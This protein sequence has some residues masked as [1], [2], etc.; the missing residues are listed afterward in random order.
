MWPNEKTAFLIIHGIGEQNPFET[1]DLFATTFLKVLNGKN[2]GSEIKIK[3]LLKPRTVN[4][5]IKWVENYISLVKEDRPGCPIDFYEYYWAHKMEGK[6]TFPEIVDWLIKISDGAKTFYDENESI[7]KEYERNKDDAFK[8]GRFKS[9]W[10]LKHLGWFLRLLTFLRIPKIPYFETVFEFIRPIVNMFIGKAKKLFVDYLGDAAIYTTT[11]VKSKHYA[12]R[13]SILDDSVD[14]VKALIEDK[15]Y[16]KIIIAGHSLGSVVAFDTLNRINHGMNVNTIDQN[17]ATKF[18]GFITF[19]SPLDKIAFFFREHVPIDQYLRRQIL[20]HFHSF[21]AKDLNLSSNF[22]ANEFK[23]KFMI[24]GLCDAI[25]RDGYNIS[26]NTPNN[27]IDWLNKL[28]K[29]VNFYDELNKKKQEIGFSEDIKELV[30]KT[31]NYRN[32]KKFSDLKNEEQNTIKRL[33]R[34]LLEETYPDNTPKRPRVINPFEAL[35]DE[36]TWINFYDDDNDPISGHLDYYKGVENI[37]CDGM[38]TQYGI[39]HNSY[40]DYENMY[41]HIL[42]TLF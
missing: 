17:L 18:K 38:D 9:R 12:I 37:S 14:E 39:S 11:D 23:G 31:E 16:G 35:L 25:K 8:G 34:L 21:K 10:Y 29:V 3:H 19:G 2:S 6:I 26:L 33:N 28:L 15:S 24:D 13:K 7:A 1:L 4:N 20:A 36:I 42:E 22:Y 32:N 40:W 5:E 27:T 30:K 41:A